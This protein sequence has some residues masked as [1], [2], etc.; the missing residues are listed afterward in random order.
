MQLV[1]ASNAQ[2]HDKFLRQD[3]SDR[4]SDGCDSNSAHKKSITFVLHK[5]S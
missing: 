5:S 1:A 3:Y 2:A 4:I